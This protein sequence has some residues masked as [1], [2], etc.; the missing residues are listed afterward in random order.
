M[1]FKNIENFYLNFSPPQKKIV[2]TPLYECMI[3]LKERNL[4]FPNKAF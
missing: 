2:F 1:Y 3:E 4:N